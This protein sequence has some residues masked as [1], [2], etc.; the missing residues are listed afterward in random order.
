MAPQDAAGKAAP[1]EDDSH[2]ELSKT[3]VT[4]SEKGNSKETSAQ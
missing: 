3:T 4:R 1:A 2:D